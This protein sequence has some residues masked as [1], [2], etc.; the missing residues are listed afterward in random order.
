MSERVV[1]TGANRG[2]GL[3]L[4][5]TYAG[6]GA[7]VWAGCRRPAEAT[8]LREIT[9]H[10]HVLDLGSTESIEA[11]AAALGDAPIDVLIN[12]GGVDARSFGVPDGERDVLQ[13]SGEHF[14]E[15][16]RIN[17]LGP[18]LLTRATLD[19]LRATPRPRIVNVTSQV[20]SMEIA[21]VTGRD[22][23]YTSSK[24]TLNMITVK[25]ASRLRDEGVIAIA[26]HPGFLRTDM[27]GAGADLDPA[28]AAALIVALIDGLSLEQSGQFLR[29][30]GTVHPW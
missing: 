14:L 7:E 25:L 11:F 6:A 16:M 17:A 13:L 12:N 4:A 18:L 27:G 24:A 30:N 20:G 15:E 8:T 19:R 22:I 2:L 5:R 3:E 9:D 29:W 1:I 28:E 10:V 23:G 21:K 26:L